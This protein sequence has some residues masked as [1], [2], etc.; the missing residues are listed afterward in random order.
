MKVIFLGTPEFAE[1]IL[2]AVCAS[3]HRVVAV[4]TQ[5][6]KVNARGKKVVASPVKAA[7]EELGL[8]VYQFE[9]ISRDGVDVLRALN[10]DIMVTAAY[11]QIL[12]REILSLCPHGVINAHGS[13]LPKYRGASP[14]QCA[15]LN[16]EPETGITVMKT[17][18]EVDS[19]DI[20]LIKKITLRGHENCAEVMD[21]LAKAG[22]EAIVEALDSIEDGR[23]AFTPQDHSQA[24]FCKKINKEDGK[25]DFSL[26]AG[27]IVNRVRAFTPGLRRT[28]SR[29]TAGLR[30]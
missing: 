19:G 12:S 9:R 29:P 30:F 10:A 13:I 21:M 7:A 17:E 28:A 24:T 5:P 1:T 14:V 8:P 26:D 18:Y 16:G 3:R 6:D 23:A 15:L 2:R 25:I 22:G 27:E 20:I 11:G 4:V